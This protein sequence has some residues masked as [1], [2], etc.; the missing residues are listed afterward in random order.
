MGRVF[1]QERSTHHEYRSFLCSSG[2][3]P[4]EHPFPERNA[5]YQEEIEAVAGG[6]VTMG[7]EEGQA[8]ADVRLH[9]GTFLQARA[10]NHELALERLCEQVYSTTAR[11]T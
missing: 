6:V 8:V 1:L 5:H 11:F 2:E 10:A 3:T 7:I 9:D 4:H